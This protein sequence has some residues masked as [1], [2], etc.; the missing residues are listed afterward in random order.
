MK[1][2]CD[3]ATQSLSL[4]LAACAR[5]YQ[6]NRDLEPRSQSL[7]RW[8]ICRTSWALCEA[9]VDGTRASLAI[10]PAAE[11]DGC[12]SSFALL[13][14]ADNKE[15]HRKWSCE[16]KLTVKKKN[17]NWSSFRYCCVNK[18]TSNLF[19]LTRGNK[20]PCML[21]WLPVRWTRNKCPPGK[22]WRCFTKKERSGS[23]NVCCVSIWTCVWAKTW[24]KDPKSVCA[25]MWAGRLNNWNM[26]FIT[27]PKQCD[28]LAQ[29]HFLL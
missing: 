25:Q 21:G 9:E 20:F 10:K 4:S 19:P 23:N 8:W 11:G 29:I 15:W 22:E 24:L 16:S 6:T 14:S 18:N 17:A 7:A 12:Y 2:G 27:S 3:G 28:T 26:N 1:P 13:L 5:S